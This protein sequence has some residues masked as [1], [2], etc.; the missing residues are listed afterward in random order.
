MTKSVQDAFQTGML[1]R[2]LAQ[3]KIGTVQIAGQD[4]IYCISTTAHA[5]LNRGYDVQIIVPSVL[6]I[7]PD[8]QTRCFEQLKLRGAKIVIHL[9]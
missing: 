5:A 3:N 7:D 1:D 2:F 8:K 6:S 4:G 9:P